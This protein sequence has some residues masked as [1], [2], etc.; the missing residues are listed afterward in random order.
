MEEETDSL[1]ADQV[2]IEVVLDRGLMHLRAFED[3][4]ARKVQA[5]L[6]TVKDDRYLANERPCCLMLLQCHVLEVR[7]VRAR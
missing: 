7:V 3:I 4:M 1:G 5:V 6:A 2:G